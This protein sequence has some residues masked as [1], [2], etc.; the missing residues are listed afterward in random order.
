[1]HEP[2]M[3]SFCSK[4][5]SSVQ[6]KVAEAEDTAVDVKDSAVERIDGV[7]ESSHIPTPESRKLGG[8]FN[9]FQKK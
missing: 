4:H 2:G 8:F 5:S 3:F 9:I 1:M 7:R 6:D